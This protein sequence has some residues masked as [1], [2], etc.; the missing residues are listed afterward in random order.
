MSI[1][2]IAISVTALVF[3]IFVFTE[4]R[5]RDRRDMFLRLHELLY[6]DDLQRGRNT[7]FRKVTDETSVEQLDDQEYRDVIRVLG[8]YNALGL[9][10]RKKY[11]NE[12][13]VL[14]T[15]SESS[16]RMW[17]RAQSVRDYREKNEGYRPWD[18]LELLGQKAQQALLK[19]GSSLPEITDTNSTLRKDIPE[20]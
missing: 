11:V 13:D 17:I 3:S 18:N 9:Y 7:L 8:A 12:R 10:I 6:S 15:W 20:S 16:Y 5:R 4:N 1:L 2:P 14:D 19:K